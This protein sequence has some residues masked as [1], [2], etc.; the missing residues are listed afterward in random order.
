[1]D[2]EVIKRLLVRVN[3]LRISTLVTMVKEEDIKD[4]PDLA[5]EVDLVVE[6]EEG[7]R[8]D[9][10]PRIWALI[11]VLRS[12]LRPR[13]SSRMLVFFPSR[14]RRFGVKRS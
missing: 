8:V 6:V 9:I 10:M 11:P 13:S 4:R 2:S 12:L 7:S 5:D 14:R 1:M 3:S